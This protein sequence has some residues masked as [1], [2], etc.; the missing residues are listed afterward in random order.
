MGSEE[1]GKKR[2]RKFVRCTLNDCVKWIELFNLTSVSVMHVRILRVLKVFGQSDQ[3]RKG[4][5][6]ERDGLN[7]FAKV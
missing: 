7:L 5:R 4:G 2:S 1:S 6:K 3:S